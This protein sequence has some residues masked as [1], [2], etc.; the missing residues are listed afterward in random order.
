V[1][2]F[3]VQHGMY[4][5]G[6]SL[7]TPQ[8]AVHHCDSRPVENGVDSAVQHGPCIRFAPIHPLRRIDFWRHHASALTHHRPTR[9]VPATGDD[10]LDQSRCAVRRTRANL[11]PDPV[12]AVRPLEEARRPPLLA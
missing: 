9:L 10:R 6:H 4:D 11:I 5:I 3:P 7:S 12:S 1:R 8:C 2:R